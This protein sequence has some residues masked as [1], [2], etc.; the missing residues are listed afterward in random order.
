MPQ[1][2][3]KMRITFATS[4]VQEALRER[5]GV[6][7]RGM[8][9]LAER[10]R[11]KA[12]P[13]D[14]D[15]I[16]END[17]LIICV[18]EF[19]SQRAQLEK[20]LG[21]VYLAGDINEDGSLEFDEFASVVTHLSPTI[22]DRF[23]QKVFEAAH[24]YTKP[25]RI[26]FARFLDVILLERVLSPTPVNAA[27]K[28]RSVPASITAGTNSPA[29]SGGSHPRNSTLKTVV[30]D[31]Q[32]EL[33]QFELLRETWA[34]DREAVQQ[35]LQ[36][37]ITH[38]PT[39]KILSFRVAFLDQLLN[40][41]VDSK[42]AWLCHRQ[43]MREIARYQ[44]LDAD[45]IEG[46]RSKEQQFKKAVRAIRNAQWIRTISTMPP[47]D[48]DTASGEASSV[49]VVGTAGIDRPHT[50]ASYTAAVQFSLD[51][52]ATNVVD[53]AALENELRETFL[54]RADEGTIDDYMKAMEHIRRVS[55]NQQSLQLVFESR[56]ELSSLRTEAT[57]PEGNEESEV[58]E[59][60][61]EYDGEEVAA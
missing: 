46:L 51:V 59:D 28:T 42:T 48:Q 23:L 32:E 18:E 61:A 33:Y 58:E 24:D 38:E 19:A 21:A 14:E 56:E 35:V 36:T 47:I 39:A 45:Q 26:S 2:Q 12:I 27:P 34:H 11:S 17:L 22:D 31:E 41:R 44:H 16:R 54:E 53:V 15:F 25:H 3:F 4:T 9:A 8:D 37:S 1:R 60:E 29:N 5:F 57:V 43:I 55:L 40:R 10:V 7:A 49:E 30:P 50:P 6:Y 13:R 20:V 52:E